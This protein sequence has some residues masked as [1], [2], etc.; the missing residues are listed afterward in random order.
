VLPNGR[1]SLPPATTRLS[2]RPVSLQWRERPRCP[3]PRV[4]PG[5]DD[6]VVHA[7]AGRA[8][9]LR[10]CRHRVRNE[11]AARAPMFGHQLHRTIAPR[12]P[13]TAGTV[14]IFRLPEAPRRRGVR[15]APP[16]HRAFYDRAVLGIVNALRFASTRPVA[17]PA[18]IDDAS[19]RHPFGNCAMV[20]SVMTARNEVDAGIKRAYVDVITSVPR[21]TASVRHNGLR[22]A[23]SADALRA[24]SR[25]HPSPHRSPLHD[26]RRRSVCTLVSCELR[27]LSR[28]IVL[29]TMRRDEAAFTSGMITPWSD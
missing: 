4:A 10:L 13:T 1:R 5:S 26:H 20:V 14:C 8:P 22:S 25:A 24:R 16:H 6:G 21:G 29:R 11:R 9:C 15:I 12:L 18:G 2:E 19:A 28:G 23:H 27:H 3:G 17:G 7:I